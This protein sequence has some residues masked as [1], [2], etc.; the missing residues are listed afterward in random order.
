M[1]CWE[2]EAITMVMK[3]NTAELWGWGAAFLPKL[4]LHPDTVGESSQSWV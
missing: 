2:G 3:S 4:V 1:V